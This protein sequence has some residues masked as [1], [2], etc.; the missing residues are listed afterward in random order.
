MKH[1]SE[2]K[3]EMPPARLKGTENSQIVKPVKYSSENPLQ[4]SCFFFKN[5]A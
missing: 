3:A 1:G 2:A 4:G 5:G